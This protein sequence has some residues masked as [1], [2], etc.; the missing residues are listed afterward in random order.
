MTGVQSIDELNEQLRAHAKGMYTYEAAT[1]V[2]IRSGWTA[3]TS[4]QND[5]LEPPDD[6]SPRFWI[7]WDAL[8]EI[9]DPDSMR[10]SQIRAA[11]GGELRLLR[12]AHSMAAGD[13]SN[14]VPGLDRANIAI[15]LAAIA[16]LG[17]SHEHS[18]IVADPEGQYEVNGE[19]A[20]IRRL[21]PLYPWPDET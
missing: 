13:L 10:Y 15:V 16:H 12:L 17:G 7:N 21:G 14:D 2:L 5:V 18:D 9:L 20:S 3:R 4:F 1:E 6:E 19:R 8:G 11:S